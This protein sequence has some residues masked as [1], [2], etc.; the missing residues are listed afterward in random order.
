MC[1]RKQGRKLQKR[2]GEKGTASESAKGKYLVAGSCPPVF[3]FFLTWSSTTE[4]PRNEHVVLPRWKTSVAP[5]EP[6]R[7]GLTR[8]QIQPLP[9]RKPKTKRTQVPKRQWQQANELVLHRPM[10]NKQPM[11][12]FQAAKDARIGLARGFGPQR[13]LRASPCPDVRSSGAISSKR[14]GPRMPTHGLETAT[15]S[16]A[17]FALF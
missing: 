11:A 10:G 6:L 4:Q 2:N 7:P 15:C 17:R 13:V 5:L 1:N 8:E 3:C 9:S 14:F 16:R 12:H